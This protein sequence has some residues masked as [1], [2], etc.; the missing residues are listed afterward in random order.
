M[1]AVKMNAGGHGSDMKASIESLMCLIRNQPDG[2][3]KPNDL[4]FDAG[5][6]NIQKP[7]SH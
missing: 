2:D 4:L 5:N 6:L 1:G 3:P 7:A